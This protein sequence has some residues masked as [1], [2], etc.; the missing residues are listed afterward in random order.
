ML[1]DSSKLVLEREEEKGALLPI[2]GDRLDRK[3]VRGISPETG[4]VAD[5]AAPAPPIP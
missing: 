1:C 5:A 3:Y 4:A 2:A